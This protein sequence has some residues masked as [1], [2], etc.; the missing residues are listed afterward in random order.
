[1]N[2]TKNFNYCGYNFKTY[3]NP[4][5]H[6]WEV[7]LKFEN[8]PLFVGNFVHKKEA[9]E[10][11]KHFNQQVPYFFN[12]YEFPFKGPHQY[13]TKFLTN[14]LYT[15]YYAWLDKKFA[16]YNKEYAKASKNDEKYYK[17]MQPVWKK[18]S[19]RKSA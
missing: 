12:K 2:K 3:C 18:Y 8:K 4:V 1:M 6:G 13:M 17:K 10:W 14:F 15:D 5:G 7:G 19:E 16:K 9:L 11:W